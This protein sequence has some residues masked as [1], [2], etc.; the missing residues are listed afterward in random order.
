MFWNA[1]LWTVKQSFPDFKSVSIL[2]TL[3]GNFDG[4]GKDFNGNSSRNECPTHISHSSYSHFLAHFLESRCG[5]LAAQP[6][7]MSRRERFQFHIL[8][9]FLSCIYPRRT[10]Q[11]FRLSV[12]QKQLCIFWSTQPRCCFGVRWTGEVNLSFFQRSTSLSSFRT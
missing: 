5:Q 11:H 9:L 6:R 10:G 7:H 1:A 12:Q 4:I 3:S 8:S 2:S